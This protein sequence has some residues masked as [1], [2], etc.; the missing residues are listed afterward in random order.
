MTCRELFK[1]LIRHTRDNNHCW[2]SLAYLANSIG[3]TPRT[4]QN[5]LGLLVQ[6]G[7]VRV[8]RR[9]GQSSLYSVNPEV[10]AFV[11]NMPSANAANPRK[12]FR[13]AEPATHEKFSGTHEKFSPECI[14]KEEFKNSPLP[15]TATDQ[16]TPPPSAV[17]L[18]EERGAFSPSGKKEQRSQAYAEFERVW[19][20][21]PIKQAREVAM[22][23]F[24][25]L[26]HARRLPSVEIIVSVIERHAQEDSRWRRGKIPMLHRW[27]REGRWLD[28][29][30]SEPS[31]STFVHDEPSPCVAR[32]RQRVVLSTPP[33]PVAV[34]D[35]AFE[36]LWA[37]WGLKVARSAAVGFWSKLSA[38]SKA[39]LVLAAQDFINSDPCNWPLLPSWL[40]QH[41]V[42][43]C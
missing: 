18:K 30:Y 8:E 24:L 6:I 27:L 4:L 17:C 36:K 20:S 25:Q 15:P 40:R 39:Q 28:V 35:S 10:M 12:V 31:E 26:R 41:A 32:A 29:P 23:T 19:Q 37:C 1:A 9:P 2:P 21:W 7:M 33:A 38:T 14:N 13:G 43:V 16:I 3:V 34:A 5:Q 22:R 11:R 42:E